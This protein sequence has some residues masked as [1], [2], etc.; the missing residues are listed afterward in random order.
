M[1]AA[2]AHKQGLTQN[3][4]KAIGE[5]LVHDFGK[6]KRAFFVRAQFRIIEF[7]SR[8]YIREDGH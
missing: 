6:V 8:A 5:I 7:I 1:Q 2:F 3:I 4:K